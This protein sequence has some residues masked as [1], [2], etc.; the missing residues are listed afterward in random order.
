MFVYWAMYLIP[1]AAVLSPLRVRKSQSW[2]PWF[3][4]AAIFTAV[5]GFRHNVGGDW[6]TYQ[7]H[8]NDISS[9]SLP[10]VFVYGDPGYYLLNWTVARLGGSIY[11]VNFVCAAVLMAGT[12]QFCRRQPRP[13]LAF[14]VAVPYMLV[15]VGTGYTR[16]SVALGFALLG[17]AALGDARLRAFIIWVAIGAAFHKSAVLLLPIAALAASRNR[18]AT[19]SLTGIISL[20]LYYLLLA[21][22]AELLW[23]NYVEAKYES[24]GG[25]IRVAMNAL[26][27]LI[28]LVWGGR[29]TTI[30]EE[31]RLWVWM[32]LL[33]LVCVPLVSFASTAV[34][35]V[36][37][38]LIPVQIYVFSRLPSL[39]R[40]NHV[41][42]F[43]MLS[44]VA[45]YAVVLFVWLNFATHAQS[46]LPYQFMP[47]G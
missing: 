44:T 46:W 19:A 1:L 21:D 6:V 23:Q 45:F 25:A 28:F 34:D 32:S 38:Y 27:A 2:V 47:L 5:M 17:L 29:L 14:A 30:G 18:V 4:V 7:I 10:G 42:S 9:M 37:L 13:W 15:V 40:T 22:S 3:M 33:A 8:F 11:W 26:P 24:D 16:Q 20:L 43:L 12:I 41:R 35:R 39:A 31:R 36:A